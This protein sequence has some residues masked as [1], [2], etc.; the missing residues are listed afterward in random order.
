MENI[1]TEKI[2]KISIFKKIDDKNEKE[3]RSKGYSIVGWINH[4]VTLQLLASIFMVTFTFSGLFK[5]IFISVKK[6]VVKRTKDEYIVGTTNIAIPIIFSITNWLIER[7]VIVAT[8]TNIIDLI[9]KKPANN[10]LL[11][12][13]L[14]PHTLEPLQ[15]CI[16]AFSLLVSAFETYLWIKAIKTTKKLEIIKDL[17]Q[18]S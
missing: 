3:L 17:Q 2:E 10:N 13:D 1:T 5:L 12:I 11:I 14:T 7:T 15:I 9:P 8:I 6:F 18:N 4:I 16:I